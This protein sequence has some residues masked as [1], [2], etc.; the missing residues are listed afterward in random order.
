MDYY[1][2]FKELTYILNTYLIIGCIVGVLLESAVEEKNRL[3]F[4]GKISLI[5]V[6]PCALWAIFKD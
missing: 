5:T 6:W 4:M 3:S 2:I 1:L